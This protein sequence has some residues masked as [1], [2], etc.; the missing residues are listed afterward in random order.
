MIG[1]NLLSVALG[2]IGTSTVNIYRFTGRS[3]NS[4]GNLVSRFAAPVQAHVSV[5]AV[6]RQ[7][8]HQLGLD[9]QKSYIMVYAVDRIS[10]ILRDTSGD[11]VEWNNVFWQTE[12]STEWYNIDGWQSTICVD[13]GLAVPGAVSVFD[14]TFDETFG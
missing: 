10:D 12:S 2:I 11:L 4:I 14:A 8:M 7:L 13:V 3:R 5:Q 1:S 9:M 6:P